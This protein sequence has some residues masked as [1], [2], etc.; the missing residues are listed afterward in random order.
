[1]V[2]M[3]AFAFM[4]LIAF[5]QTD[6]GSSPG[7]GEAISQSE[8]I[9]N[10]S[11]DVT[12]SETK[13]DN[14]EQTTLEQPTSEE[15]TEEAT[16]EEETTEEETSEESTTTKEKATST[17]ESKGGAAGTVNKNKANPTVASVDQPGYELTVVGEEQV[18]L[19]G[20]LLDGHCCVLHLF[21]IIIAALLLLVYARD[22]KKRQAR[23]FELE[24]E[25]EGYF[26]E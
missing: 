13:Q 21:L 12:S 2:V 6:E 18:P 25:L 22:M 1:M 5:A 26:E 11:N 7:A 23:I 20:N 19:A 14:S 17:T 3:M 10:N 24:A 4:P 8:E 16:T 9:A 15:T